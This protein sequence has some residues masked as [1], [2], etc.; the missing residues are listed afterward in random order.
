[1]NNK[2]SAQWGTLSPIMKLCIVT[3]FFLLLYL[4]AEKWVENVNRSAQAIKVIGSSS[5]SGRS[6]AVS[7]S[8]KTY[9]LAADFEKSNPLTDDLD[10]SL[11]VEV[12]PVTPEPVREIIQKPNLQTKQK[13][14]T[15][16]DYFVHNSLKANGFED[17]GAFINGAYYLWE[18]PLNSPV[19]TPNGSFIPKLIN[20]SNGN[21]IVSVNGKRFSLKVGQ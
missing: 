17:D 7:V 1:M 5:A 4:S 3:G 13:P 6:R 12:E 20:V 15:P 2:L 21:V 19:I 10:E 9:Y 11:F 14:K 16:L 8:T 18:E